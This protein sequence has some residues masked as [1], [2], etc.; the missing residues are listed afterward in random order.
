MEETLQKLNEQIA[1]ARA[2]SSFYK[3]L[4]AEP[5]SSIEELK[6]LP[7]M[8]ASDLVEHG[9]K[10]LCCPVSQIR[11]MVTMQTSGTTGAPK[12]LA[13]TERDLEDTVEF[14]REGMHLLC[15][16]GDTVMIFMPGK[17]PDGLCDLLSREFVDLVEIR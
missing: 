17:N 11:R 8:T 15:D 13:F 7:L 16:T 14:F 6:H 12:R 9:K 10:I 1:Y 4:P 5:L 2:N 3:Y